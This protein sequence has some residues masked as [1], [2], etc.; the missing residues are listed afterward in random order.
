MILITGVLIS[1]NL[2]SPALCAEFNSHISLD[3]GPQGSV[4]PTYIS[5]TISLPLA[6]PILL[7]SVETYCFYS[8]TSCVL[9]S[10]H[11]YVYET[12]FLSLSLFYSSF[13]GVSI[14]TSISKAL[15]QS[16]YIFSAPIIAAHAEL[17][18]S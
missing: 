2:V 15:T 13:N 7:L 1:G 6:T 16:G 17:G 14:F 3:S 8:V 10:G 18:I 12:P 4:L 5:V 9:E 11:Y